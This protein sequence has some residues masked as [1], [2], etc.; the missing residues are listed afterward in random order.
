M[1][2]III[3]Y[4][5]DRGFLS[6]CIDSIDCGRILLSYGE[7]SVAENFN[8][9]L[10]QV[11]TEFVKFIAEDDYF[12]PGGIRGLLSGIGDADWC[13]GNSYR[14][15][16]GKIVEKYKPDTLDFKENIIR[17]R[18]DGGTTLYRAEVL[19]EIGGMDETLWTGEEYDMHLRLMSKGFLPKHVDTFVYVHRIWNGQ[20]SRIYRKINKYKR[21]EAIKEIQARYSDSI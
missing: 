5:K 11:D 18:I 14:E 13:V 7:R 20:K 1:V 3:P 15:S 6:Q 8:Y 19:R 9:A 16:G 4:N 10:R 17:N 21:D 12:I 2:T